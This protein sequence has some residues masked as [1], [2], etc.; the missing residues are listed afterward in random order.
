MRLS[1]LRAVR[2]R[3]G[4]LVRWR[5]QSEAWVVGFDLY[6]TTPSGSVRLNRTLIPALGAI[7]G[8]RYFWRDTRIAGAGTS[9]RLLAVRADGTP[10]LAGTAPLRG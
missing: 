2:T 9:Y 5:T 6:R 8:R 4:A 3:G 7:H 10:E 1:E